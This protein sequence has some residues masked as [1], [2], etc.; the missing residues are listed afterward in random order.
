MKNNDTFVDFNIYGVGLVPG[1]N[2]LAKPKL[3]WLSVAEVNHL[4]P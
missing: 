4:Y 3:I 2:I 1:G